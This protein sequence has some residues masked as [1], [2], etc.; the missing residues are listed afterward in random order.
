MTSAKKNALYPSGF[1]ICYPSS[2]LEATD[3]QPTPDS[4]WLFSPSSSHRTR[5]PSVHSPVVILVDLGTSQLFQEHP[6][7]DLWSWMNVYVC[8]CTCIYTYI[9]ICE[10]LPV[11]LVDMNVYW[12]LGLHDMSHRTYWR[13]L[14]VNLRSAG[15]GKSSQASTLFATGGDLHE[16]MLVVPMLWCWLVWN[17]RLFL[18]NTSF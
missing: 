18:K 2:H 14:G 11:C 6:W 3:V 13:G 12:I 5:R 16:F 4:Y 1:I 7:K 10:R 8:V 17:I 15:S 9:Y